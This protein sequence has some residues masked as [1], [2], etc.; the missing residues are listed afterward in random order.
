VRD[1]AEKAREAADRE[2]TAWRGQGVDDADDDDGTVEIGEELG[3]L[4]DAWPPRT[5]HDDDAV[6]VFEE[7]EEDRAAAAA[8]AA[9]AAR[10]REPPGGM[11]LTLDQRRQCS[12]SVFFCESCFHAPFFIL[13]F[14]FLVYF[15]YF[16]SSASKKRIL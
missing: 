13:S 14:P 8:A 2:A 3:E 1:C 9:A 4:V 5:V 10:S 6:V 7:R 11:F 12:R 15:A 16:L